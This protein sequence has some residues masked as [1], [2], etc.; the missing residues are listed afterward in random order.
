MYYE[1]GKGEAGG[2]GF[3]NLTKSASVGAGAGLQGIGIPS[4]HLGLSGWAFLAF[5]VPTGIKAL[6]AHIEGEIA[7][8][9]G[10]DTSPSVYVGFIRAGGVAIGN[11]TAGGSILKGK[12]KTWSLHP[13]NA[14][15]YATDA[16]LSDAFKPVLSPLADP[17]NSLAN[18]SDMNSYWSNESKTSSP[19]H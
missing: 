16:M 8:V 13:L 11:E 14:F 9:I 15:N 10:A 4:R 19:A 3:K 7:L 5:E 12:E 2:Y 1:P 6:G 18:P 17:D